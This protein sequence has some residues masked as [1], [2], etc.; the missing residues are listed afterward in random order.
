[1]TFLHSKRLLALLL[2]AAAGCGKSSAPHQTIAAPAGLG[3]DANPAAYRLGAAI[4]ANAPHSSGGA[5]ASYAISP[6]LP[7]GLLLDAAT[8]VI[9]GTPAALAPQASYTVTAANAG[10]S[11]TCALSIAVAD[12]PP[13]QLVY[14]MPQATYT[15]GVAIPADVPSSSGGAIISYSVS[16]ALPAGLAIDASTGVISGTPTAVSARFSYTVT[17]SNSGGSAGKTE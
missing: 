4:A 13:T 15:R 14:G 3:Y 7:A 16:P 10:G 17:A 11:T 2:A 6:A 9:S 1:M 5:V 12:A 8:G